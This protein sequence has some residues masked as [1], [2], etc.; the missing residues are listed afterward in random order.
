MSFVFEILNKNGFKKIRNFLDVAPM[1]F[2]SKCCE[3]G[4][5]QNDEKL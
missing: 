3:V 5:G 4:S 2:H 1:F